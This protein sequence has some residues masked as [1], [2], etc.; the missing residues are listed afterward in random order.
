MFL[1][2]YGPPFPP[3]SAVER[4]LHRFRDQGLGF[5]ASGFGM[6]DLEFRD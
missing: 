4:R 5:K 3:Q 1:S 6:R 2:F